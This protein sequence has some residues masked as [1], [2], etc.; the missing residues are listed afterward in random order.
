MNILVISDIHNDVENLMN[1]I[2]KI[3]FLKFD[4]IVAVGD[5]TD[6]NLP[7]GF[8]DVDIAVLVMEEL[9]TFKTPILAVPGNFDKNLIEFFEERG[10]SLHGKGKIVE[11]VGFYGFGGAR[12][13][14]NTPLEPNEREIKE[15]L[16][17]AYEQI[18]NCELKV[19]V[20]HM[21]PART[22]LDVLFTGA[23][24]GSETIRN[25]IEEKQPDVAISAHIHEAR[26]LDEL[27]KTK[28]I[29]SGRFPEG[30]CGFITLEKGNVSTKIVNLI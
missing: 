15:G 24:V 3:S 17:K 7:K 12:T 16:T 23:H 26:G 9:N 25:F 30:Y 29:N 8:R 13:P 22:K 5:F 14:Y 28:L 20:T 19:Q 21:P 6:V 10:I 11:N 1:F 18:K 4:I 27:G 2:D